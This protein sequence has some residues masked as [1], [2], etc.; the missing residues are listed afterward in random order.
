MGIVRGLDDLAQRQGG[1]P[2][3]AHPVCPLLG[4]PLQEPCESAGMGQ[5]GRGAPGSRVVAHDHVQ[6]HEDELRGVRPEHVFLLG[7]GRFVQRLDPAQGVGQQQR[8]QP[9]QVRLPVLVPGLLVVRLLRPQAFSKLALLAQGT[10]LPLQGFHLPD[11][12]PGHGRVTGVHF[13]GESELV[14]YPKGFLG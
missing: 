7:Q 2:E 11:G 4:V 12:S 10:E 13:R 9:V 5:A 14:T 6:W 8:E 3:A 1:L